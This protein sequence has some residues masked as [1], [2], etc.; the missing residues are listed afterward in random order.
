MERRASVDCG[1]VPTTIETDSE[2]RV[3]LLFALDKGGGAAGAWWNTSRGAIYPSALNALRNSALTGLSNRQ[4]T[5][6]A[7]EATDF[8]TC[9]VRL[10]QARKA[11]R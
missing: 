8:R 5:S 1:L 4:R 2:G 6:T 10:R 11:R 7:L 3:V 9:S